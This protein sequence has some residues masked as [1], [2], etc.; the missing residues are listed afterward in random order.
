MYCGRSR[1]WCICL[2]RSMSSAIATLLRLLLCPVQL[3]QAPCEERVPAEDGRH[4]LAVQLLEDAVQL[5]DTVPGGRAQPHDCARRHLP[6]DELARLRVVVLDT[7]TRYPRRYCQCLPS[8]HD[9][10]SLRLLRRGLLRTLCQLLSSLLL[11]RL[12]RYNPLDVA[13]LPLELRRGR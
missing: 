12:R 11:E 7:L 9:L 1:G 5:L 3:H 10:L 6:G 13:S 4:R 8:R 2:R